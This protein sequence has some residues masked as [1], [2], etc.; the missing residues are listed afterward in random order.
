MSHLKEEPLSWKEFET[1]ISN[2]VRKI[3]RG[4]ASSKP[5]AVADTYPIRSLETTMYGDAP[6]LNPRNRH[7]ATARV[8]D[9]EGVSQQ[10]RLAVTVE[11]TISLIV[12]DLIRRYY[13]DSNLVRRLNEEAVDIKA[14]QSILRTL[15]MWICSYQQHFIRY[16]AKY[17]AVR[18]RCYE[19]YLYWHDART[20]VPPVCKAFFLLLLL[21]FART[22]FGINS[23]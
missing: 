7:H 8:E 14:A 12:S 22:D 3:E 4:V 21:W 9:V 17:A 5:I 2:E 23:L 11:H 16:G 20:N 6:I 18:R 10:F 1:L 19:F 13:D 15:K